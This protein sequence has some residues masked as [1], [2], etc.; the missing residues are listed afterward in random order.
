M[1][2]YRYIYIY[3]YIYSGTHH[4]VGKD[5]DECRADAHQ[6]GCAVANNPLLRMPVKVS[7]VVRDLQIEKEQNS[8][9]S[10]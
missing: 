9:S 6:F 3:I 1:Y 8:M 10:P 7:H 2:V 5:E 4:R